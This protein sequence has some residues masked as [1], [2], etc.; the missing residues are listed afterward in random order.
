MKKLL[1]I[2]LLLVSNYGFSQLKAVIIDS[3][4]KERIPFVNIWVADK[5]IGTTS[6]HQGKFEITINEPHVIVF[7]A[8]GYDTRRIASDSILNIVELKSSITE[9]DEVVV[10]ANKQDLEL[11]I[12]NFKKY[13]VRHYFSCGNNPWI[14]ARYFPYQESYSETRLLDAIKILTK[15]EVRD[16]KFNVR[17]Y[18]VNEEGEP[19]KYIYHK[20]IIG[21]A[22]KGKKETKIDLSGL[23][24]EF[25]SKGFFVAIEWL[26]IDSNIYYYEIADYDSGE[27]LK[28]INYAPSI[29][30]LLSKTEENSWMFTQGRWIKFGA[31][32]PDR[33]NLLAIEL[34]LTN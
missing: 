22:R 7:S 14:A 16:A 20:N 19:D 10:F 13:K 6:N 15:S 1:V 8:I 2:I 30:A 27:I 23:N 26:I 9:L 24:I 32:Q 31:T 12:G 5:S 21:T 18:S 3:E 34:T 28:R 4:T 33:Y 25:P 11:T 17:L 29:G